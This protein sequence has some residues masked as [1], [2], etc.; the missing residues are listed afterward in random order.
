MRKLAQ[1]IVSIF[2]IAFLISTAYGFPWMAGNN[3]TTQGN[4]TQQGQIATV[5]L[6]TTQSEQDIRLVQHLI[7]VDAVQFQSENRL[8]VRE[9][10][11]FKNVGTQNFSGSLRTWVPDG[12][13]I[14]KRNETG[15]IAK[16]EMTSGTATDYLPVVQNGNIVSWHDD[17]ETNTLASLYIIEYL[18]TANPEG[19]LTKTQVYTKMLTYPTLINYQYVQSSDLPPIVLII[20]KPQGSSATFRDENGNKISPSDVSEQG[21]SV[22]NRFNSVQFKELKI[23]ISVPVITQA[24]LAVYGI[25][26][27][28]IVLALSY[29][30]L[31]RSE[32]FQALEGKIRNA[33]KKERISR[34]IEKL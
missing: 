29:P 9:T 13:R 32:K 23:E 25:I 28:L 34:R 20:T 22:K 14:I 15:E 1:F 4:I 7:E 17:I 12:A 24:Q 11:I 16:N 27:L 33:L 5:L 10:L 2:L 31:R 18:V 3:S 6:N 21:N 30:F 19:T 8:Y 26:G